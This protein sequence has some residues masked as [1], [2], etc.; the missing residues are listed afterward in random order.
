MAY[1][2]ENSLLGVWVFVV[3]AL[4]RIIFYAYPGFESDIVETGLA[5]LGFTI[6]T[7]QDE[8]ELLVALDLDPASIV[9]IDSVGRHKELAGLLP[10]I[11]SRQSS[12]IPIFVMDSTNH[13]KTSL[14]NVRILPANHRV[15]DT[16]FAI[17]DYAKVH[18]LPEE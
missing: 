12:R 14:R 2:V 8:A 17:A 6:A 1:S 3:M 13:F 10:R 16:V 11:Q 15:H 9:L 18:V 5:N 4:P 7:V